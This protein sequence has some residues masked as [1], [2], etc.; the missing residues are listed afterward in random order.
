MRRSPTLD[1]VLAGFDAEVA[2][3]FVAWSPIVAVGHG[4][5][6]FKLW[7]SPTHGVAHA[8]RV[9]TLA[10]DLVADRALLDRAVL[11]AMLH[12]GARLDDYGDHSHAGR[13]RLFVLTKAR[14]IGEITGLTLREVIEVARAIG[15]HDAGILPGVDDLTRILSNADR[16]DRV[17]LGSPVDPA[18]M[19][20]DGRWGD[21]APIAARLVLEI[22]GTTVVERLGRG[23]A[24]C[25]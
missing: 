19:Y 17:R 8:A 18:L 25:R 22:N 23:G 3:R 6:C 21:L 10:V 4:A 7:G 12:D 16:L 2:P 20:A 24:W 9:A 15:Q 5:A 1:R 14:E 13:G 11:A